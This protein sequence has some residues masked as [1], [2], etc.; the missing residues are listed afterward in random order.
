M[1]LQDAALLQKHICSEIFNVPPAHGH[2]HRARPVG[3]NMLAGPR[4]NSPDTEDA[5]P[6]QAIGTAIRLPHETQGNDAGITLF[7]QCED[8]MECETVDRAIEL[9]GR[10][11][12]IVYTGKISAGLAAPGQ[13]IGTEDGFAIGGSISHIDGDFGTIGPFVDIGGEIFLLS[14][15]HV[16][17]NNNQAELGDTILVP[18]RGDGRRFRS[19]QAAELAEY[20][21][22]F[23]EPGI[24][25]TLDVALARMEAGTAFDPYTL[26]GTPTGPGRSQFRG[27]MSRVHKRDRVW[28][29]GSSSGWTSGTISHIGASISVRYDID[30]QPWDACFQDQIV[31]E[32]DDG[33]FSSGGDSGSLI[34]NSRNEAVALIFAS[35]DDANGS[36]RRFTYA[37]DINQVMQ[38]L[39]AQF[40]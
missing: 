30:G 23:F 32:G 31:I 1:N 35:W 12:D 33:P 8:D 11:V 39:G 40:A 2:G 37:H 15:N 10:A 7:C 28:K 38:T 26:S 5:Y 3:P 25:N 9:G 24:C 29:V 19:G 18:G 21:E 20:F 16:L 17:A 6:L 34:L 14:N 4:G 27:N 13:R 22:I 36:G